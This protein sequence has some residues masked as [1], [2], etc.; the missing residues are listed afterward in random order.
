MSERE[1]A[2]LRIIIKMGEPMPHYKEIA[3]AVWGKDTAL[4]KQKVQRA[5]AGLEKKGYVKIIT[6][7]ITREIIVL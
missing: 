7:E 3:Q 4:A 2:V 1:A 5:I 6:H